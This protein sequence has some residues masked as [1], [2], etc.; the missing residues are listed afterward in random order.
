MDQAEGIRNVIKLQNQQMTPKAR[1]ITITSGK[2]GVGKSSVAVNLAVQ[3]RKLGKRVIIFDADLGLANVEVMFGAIP[4]YNLSDLIYQG[5]GYT[6][7]HHTGSDGYRIYF[8]GVR[9]C[10]DEQSDQGPDFLSGTQ[11][12]KIR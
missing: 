4:K 8:G 10:D 5:Q 11:P 1:V 3:L 9:N 2:G 7:D 12:V 6:R